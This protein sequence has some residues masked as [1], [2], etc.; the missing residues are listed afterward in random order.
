MTNEELIKIDKKDTTVDL[1]ALGV[2]IT[3][4]VLINFVL[5]CDE[6]FIIRLGVTLPAWF[7]YMI[8]SKLLRKKRDKKLGYM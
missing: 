2:Q 4:C 7:I 1:I 3:Y 5:L 8:V 6:S